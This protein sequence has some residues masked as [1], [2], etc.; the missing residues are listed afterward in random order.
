M[1]IIPHL[2]VLK[3]SWNFDILNFQMYIFWIY[4]VFK[5]HIFKIKNVF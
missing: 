1:Y 4:K 5:F 2:Y 3:H